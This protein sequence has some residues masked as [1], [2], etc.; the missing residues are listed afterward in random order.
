MSSEWVNAL[1]TRKVTSSLPDPFSYQPD[2][3]SHRD[4]SGGASDNHH[5]PIFHSTANRQQLFVNSVLIF[6]SH[7]Q[8]RYVC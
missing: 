4:S 6:L 3:L 5:Y 8:V 2:I 1:A 7:N